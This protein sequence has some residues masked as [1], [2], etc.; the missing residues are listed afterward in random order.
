MHTMTRY[1][2]SPSLGLRC[3]LQRQSKKGRKRRSDEQPSK[4]DLQLAGLLY[5]MSLLANH[6]V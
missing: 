6:Q 5:L 4:Q 1:M 2:Y 3:L